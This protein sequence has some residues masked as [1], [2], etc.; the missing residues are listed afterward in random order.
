MFRKLKNN[1]LRYFNPTA[2]TVYMYHN[3]EDALDEVE[4]FSNKDYVYEKK[5][6]KKDYKHEWERYVNM[7]KY[8]WGCL[9]GTWVY[10][11]SGY[12]A[13]NMVLISEYFYTK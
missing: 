2:I 8:K 6:F 1:L 7:K 3:I 12:S 4:V 5:V 10:I 13:E 9:D 11:Y